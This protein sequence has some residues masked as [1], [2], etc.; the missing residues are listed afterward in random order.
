MRG[1]NAVLA[2]TVSTDEITG[3]VK[4]LFAFPIQIC[5]ATDEREVKFD[6]AAPSG[7]PR[8]QAWLDSGTGELV[9]DSQCLR[10]VRFGDDFK[11]I[12]PE[13]IKEIDNATK[14]TTMV[15]QGV[16]DLADVPFDRATGIYFVQ[17][18][19]KGG[20]P[21]SYRLLFEALRADKK[22]KR[23]AKAIVTKRTARTRQKLGA[24]YADENLGCLMLVELRFATSLR[25]P[26]EQVLSPQLAQVEEVQIDMARKVVDERLGDGL[27]A[28]GS[29]VDEAV[30]LRAKLI[31]SALAG[32]AI[33]APTPLAET[34][35]TDNLEAQLMASLGA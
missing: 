35:A 5:K 14:I 30:E 13:A 24:I 19:A 34:V 18:P 31:E 33:I 6:I 27:A 9:D 25:A 17:S 16:V 29:A 32:E 1:D 20:A 7:A 22:A 2:V 11:A 15:A 12:D 28:L 21:K 8:K 10:G 23:P 4:P 3:E 26:D